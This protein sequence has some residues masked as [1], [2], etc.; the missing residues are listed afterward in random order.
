[1]CKHVGHAVTIHDTVTHPPRDEDPDEDK[2]EQLKIQY[3]CGDG[4]F[5]PNK[6]FPISTT[7]E[8]TA[9]LSVPHESIGNDLRDLARPDTFLDRTMHQATKKP[10]RHR[11]SELQQTFRA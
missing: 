2:I 11:P 7:F 1:M 3:H 9:S 8:W 6:S 10:F 5:S 4:E